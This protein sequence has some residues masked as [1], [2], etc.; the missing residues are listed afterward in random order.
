MYKLYRVSNLA[1][2]LQQINKLYLLTIL[3]LVLL[4]ILQT[5]LCDVI[6]QPMYE[7]FCDAGWTKT[8][9]G[10]MCNVDVDECHSETRP[11]CS[12]NPPVQCINTPGSFTC[13]PC[14]AG[15]RF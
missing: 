9:D 3:S 6:G 4:T 7:C 10:P 15:S 5:I 14:P 2:W 8:Q 12:T 13:G 11:P 1:L